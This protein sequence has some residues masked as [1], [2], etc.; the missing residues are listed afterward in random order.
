[1]DESVD[2]GA[3]FSCDTYSSLLLDRHDNG[4]PGVVCLLFSFAVAKVWSVKTTECLHTFKVAIAGQAGE[5]PVLSIHINPRNTEQL[6]VCNRSNTVS[7]IN[8]QGQVGVT[9]KYWFV[10]SGVFLGHN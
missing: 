7:V 3:F 10:G 4:W 2:E 8:Q 9:L 6:F 5:L 1:M